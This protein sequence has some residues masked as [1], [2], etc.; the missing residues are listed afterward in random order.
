[1]DTQ[2]DL[3]KKLIAKAEE[4]TD[5]RASLLDN[6]SSAL[7]EAFDIQVPDDFNIVVHEDDARTAHLVLPTSPEL[8]DAQ[9]RKA[10][11]GGICG[12]GTTDWLES[13]P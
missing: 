7:K 10:A 12:S 4:D 13:L 6:P 11:G 1:M 9:L 8:S 5:F 2:Q 3:I